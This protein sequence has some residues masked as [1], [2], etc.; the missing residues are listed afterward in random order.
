MSAHLQVL[1]LDRQ[2]KSVINNIQPILFEGVSK[3][4]V[5][6][7][8]LLWHSIDRPILNTKLLLIYPNGII[9]VYENILGGRKKPRLSQI[10]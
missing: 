7:H 4:D 8:L 5:N 9:A 3:D 2:T 10:I 6:Y 1:V